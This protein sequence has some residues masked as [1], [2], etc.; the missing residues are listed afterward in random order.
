M[1]KISEKLIPNIFASIKFYLSFVFY[2]DFAQNFIN[3]ALDKECD[4]VA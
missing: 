1:T 2:L 4:L 3:L